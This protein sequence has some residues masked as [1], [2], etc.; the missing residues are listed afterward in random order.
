MRLPSLDSTSHCVGSA[1]STSLE[2]SWG[3]KRQLQSR[4]NRHGISLR[5]TDSE[6]KQIRFTHPHSAPQPVPL[7]PG[8][9]VARSWQHPRPIRGVQLAYEL[10]RRALPDE[11]VHHLRRTQQVQ[12]NGIAFRNR[13]CLPS[14]PDRVTDID[15]RFK[16]RLRS[17]SSVSSIL[18]KGSKSR[19]PGEKTG[20]RAM[21]ISTHE[22]ESD[23][24]TQRNRI[25]SNRT[26]E[27]PSLLG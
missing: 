21:A 6:S 16:A 22:P 12:R 5:I 20:V 9:K 17:I 8:L 2:E 3:T 23:Q 25:E 27:K 13:I 19:I 7:R 26:N 11:P 14:N 18:R 24:Y 1:E 10:P 4:K 15:L